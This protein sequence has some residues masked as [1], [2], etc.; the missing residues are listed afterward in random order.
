[1]ETY[2]GSKF[3]FQS[4]VAMKVEL[5]H[6]KAIFSNIASSAKTVLKAANVMRS[7]KAAFP[8]LLTL[9]QLALTLPI[10]TTSCKR[11]VSCIKRVKTYAWSSMG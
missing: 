10:S 1:M 5:L 2:T 3:K 6:T 4:T 7:V 9:Y 11:S 8:R